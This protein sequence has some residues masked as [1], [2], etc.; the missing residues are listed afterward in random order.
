M[1][2]FKLR[3]TGVTSE[4]SAISATTAFLT[5]LVTD[6]F[7]EKDS[8]KNGLYNYQ[9]FI[10]QIFWSICWRAPDLLKKLSAEE[11]NGSSNK[12]ALYLH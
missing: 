1:L 10:Y 4:R 3:I 12:M 11:S 9:K 2:R 6:I 5:D 7:L 8:S